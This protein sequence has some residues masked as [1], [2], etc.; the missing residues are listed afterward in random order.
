MDGITDADYTYTKRVC[1][2][3]GIKNVGEYHD[4]Y[5]QSYTLFLAD[6]FNSFQNRC[7]EIYGLDLA[8][9]L[10]APGLAW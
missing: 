8:H 5:V 9:F 2:G 6:V 3:F 4:L 7:L 1:K 10:F